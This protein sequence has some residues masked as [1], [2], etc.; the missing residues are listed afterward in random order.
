L[1]L[2]KHAEFINDLSIASTK[3]LA[4]EEELI[5]IKE[6]WSIQNLDMA[7]EKGVSFI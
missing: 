2:A 6:S 7:F 5:K 1:Q 3:E 4:I